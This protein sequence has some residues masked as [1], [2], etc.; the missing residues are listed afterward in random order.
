[1][2]HRGEVGYSWW[3]LNIL[4]LRHT[5]SVPSRGGLVSCMQVDTE[6][7]RA[8]AHR[9][10]FP[11]ACWERGDWSLVAWKHGIQVYSPEHVLSYAP[12]PQSI[13]TRPGPS[14][15]FRLAE[16][17]LRSTMWA[18]SPGTLAQHNKTIDH[19]GRC[20]LTVVHSSVDI[21]VKEILAPTT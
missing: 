12:T 7:F 8:E 21:R 4:E 1:M 14:L 10:S 9:L 11:S 3:A 17:L 18:S 2:S 15:A 13:S 6:F 19:T 16:P 5:Y 20:M